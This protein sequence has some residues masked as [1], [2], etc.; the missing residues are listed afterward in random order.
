[1]LTGPLIIQGNRL[2]FLS[3]DLITKDWVI[4]S[5]SIHGSLIWSPH[6]VVL[7]EELG[8][9]EKGLKIIKLVVWHIIG[10]LRR[11]PSRNGG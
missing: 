3:Q 4:C 9:V 2:P 11:K 10:H 5:W 7:L 1:M 8:S 6:D